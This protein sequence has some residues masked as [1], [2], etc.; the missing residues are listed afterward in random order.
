MKLQHLN[1]LPIYYS[2]TFF[3]F[4]T[5]LFRLTVKLRRWKKQLNNNSNGKYIILQIE[6]ASD[7]PRVKGTGASHPEPM[8]QFCCMILEERA[9]NFMLRNIKTIRTVK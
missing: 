3:I 7:S 2:S 1:F 8:L 9:K 4:V 5:K 6:A